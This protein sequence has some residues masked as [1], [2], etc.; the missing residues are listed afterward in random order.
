MLRWHTQFHKDMVSGEFTYP[1]MHCPTTPDLWQVGIDL[2]DPPQS[3]YF[4]VRW[5]PP[6]QFTMVNVSDHPSPDC[7]EPDRQ[8][9]EERRT[10]F[11][12]QEWR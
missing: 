2:G 6:Y 3:L 12:V 4:L 7:T 9:D 8:L 10:M 1:T 5:R 11:P